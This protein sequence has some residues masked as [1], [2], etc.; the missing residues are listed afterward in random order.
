MKKLLIAALG[1]LAVASTANAEVYVQGDLGYAKLKTSGFEHSGNFSGSSFS[2]SIAV[3][4]KMGD[5][6]TALDYTYYGKADS[7]YSDEGVTGK[8]DVKA[9]GFGVSA[10]YDIDLNTV[11]KPYVGVRV[12]SNQVTVKD[13]YVQKDSAGRDIR[14]YEKDSSTKFGYGAMVGANYGLAPNLDLNTALEYNRLGNW[15]GVKLNQYGLKVGL[16]YSF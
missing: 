16:K 15:D 3:G 7:S 12:S 4:Y 14:S 9:K 5:W 10:I 1:A 11:L 13:N 6:R 2:P 8:A